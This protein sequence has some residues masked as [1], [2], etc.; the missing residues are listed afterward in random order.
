MSRPSIAQAALVAVEELTGAIRWIYESPAC[1][2]TETFQQAITIL[3]RLERTA[4]NQADRS[5]QE[6][7]R[8]AMETCHV[9]VPSPRHDS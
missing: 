3:A 8:R 5:Q 7:H 1:E 6:E 9:P 4:M 2:A